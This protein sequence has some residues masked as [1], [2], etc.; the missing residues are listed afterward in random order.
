MRKK[1][2]PYFQFSKDADIIIGPMG[3]VIAD[4]LF[5]EITPAIA[6]AVGSSRAFKILIPV[7]RC[8]HLI[9][10]CQEAPLSEYLQQVCREFLQRVK[11]SKRTEL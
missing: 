1:I 4:P 10:G 5:V 8:N 3:I 7:N 2:Q 11:E 9:A 6:V